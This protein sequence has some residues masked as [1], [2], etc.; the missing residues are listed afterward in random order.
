MTPPWRSSLSRPV[1]DCSP[2]T[3]PG[4][5]LSPGL[6]LLCPPLWSARQALVPSLSSTQGNWAQRGLV[7]LPEPPSQKGAERQDWSPSPSEARA[8]RLQ[9]ALLLGGLWVA[10]AWLIAPLATGHHWYV[11]ALWRPLLQD[12]SAGTGLGGGWEPSPGHWG[13][14]NRDSWCPPFSSGLKRGTLVTPVCLP[15]ATIY[16][17]VHLHPR[18]GFLP[19]A[20]M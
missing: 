8:E 1:A 9:G 14:R 12:V 13:W 19:A 6:T 3:L 18:P 15:K 20:D 10:R 7:A 11:P 5:G 4:A 17:Q 2:L 16:C